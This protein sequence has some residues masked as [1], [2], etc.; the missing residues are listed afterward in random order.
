[1]FGCLVTAGVLAILMAVC[2]AVTDD[3]LKLEYRTLDNNTLACREKEIFDP[4]KDAIR[5]GDDV[6]VRR[7]RIDPVRPRNLWVYL[8]AE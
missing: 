6:V 1:M 3:D 7:I 8:N 2:V 5:A 4:F